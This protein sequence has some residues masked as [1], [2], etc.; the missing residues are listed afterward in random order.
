MQVLYTS[1]EVRQA[2][3]DI[4]STTRG[5]RVAISAFVGDGAEAFLPSPS[6]ISLVCWPHPSGTNP[7]TLRK[8][9]AKGVEVSFADSLHMKVYW[10]EQKGA[11]VTSANLSTNAM[12]QGDLKEFGVRLPPKQIDIDRIL[13]HLNVRP[14]S[15]AELRRL[16]RLHD[17]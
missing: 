2:I 7:R 13:Q 10:S 6:G 1:A 12:G 3:V 4:F 14:I 5:R 16:D 11:V 9:M 15:P 8:L 17:K